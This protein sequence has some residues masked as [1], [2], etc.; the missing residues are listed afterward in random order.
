MKAGY[1]S[2]LAQYNRN[3]VEGSVAVADPHR[4]IQ[5]LMDGALDKMAVA[6]GAMER[7]EHEVKVNHINWAISII[8]GLRSSLDLSAGDLANNLDA[9]YEYM[10][11]RLSEA[12]VANDIAILSEVK[13]LLGDIRDAWVAI[14]PEVRGQAR[15]NQ[16]SIGISLGA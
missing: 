10:V 5:M 14:G 12:N 8:E 1:N 11:R 15:E 7:G 16:D 2:A 3:A 9:L 13:G 4:V 6:R